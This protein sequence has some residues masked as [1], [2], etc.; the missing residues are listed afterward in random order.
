MAKF[1]TKVD[2]LAAWEAAQKSAL[3]WKLEEMRLRMLVNELFPEVERL[4]EGTHYVPLS[5]GYR[6]K[7]EHGWNYTLNGK[8]DAVAV[9]QALDKLEKIGDDGKFIAERVVKWKP[10]LSVSEYKKLRPEH[11]S[12]ID[13][14]LTTKPASPALSIVA[15]KGNK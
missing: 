6:L 12:I 14:V 5:N 9:H 2:M 11:K 7:G 15:P 8:D 10:D 3:H 1:I 4:G 13:T